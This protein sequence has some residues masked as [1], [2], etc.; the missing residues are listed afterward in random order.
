MPTDVAAAVRARGRPAAPDGRRRTAR[1]CSSTASRPA[2]PVADPA[3]GR[4]E[5]ARDRGD[6]RRRGRPELAGFATA[7]ACP[8][9]AGDRPTAGVRGSLVVA[10]AETVLRTLR[11]ALEVLASQA[12][13]A[14]ERLT[15]SQEID[16][17]N[18]EAYFRTLVQNTPTSS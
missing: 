6:P 4:G 13:L 10:A 16:R 18:S 1:C 15:L 8:L 3:P 14:L 5:P 9:V 7:L 17:R 12:A 2:C 11:G